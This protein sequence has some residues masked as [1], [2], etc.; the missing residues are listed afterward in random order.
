MI[1]FLGTLNTV[2]Y[3]KSLLN[4][5]TFSIFEFNVLLLLSKKKTVVV[6]WKLKDLSKLKLT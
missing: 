1:L 4:K 3:K 6:N 5:P 2:V